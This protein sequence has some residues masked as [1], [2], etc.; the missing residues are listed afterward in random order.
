MVIYINTKWGFFCTVVVDG[1]LTNL[2]VEPS[3]NIFLVNLTLLSTCECKV[4]LSL[5]RTEPSR[6]L[7]ASCDFFNKAIK[8]NNYTFI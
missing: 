4:G 7:N 6:S 2:M 5:S 8:C 1:N 3:L